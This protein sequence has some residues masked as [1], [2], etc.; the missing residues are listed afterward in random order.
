MKNEQVLKSQFYELSQKD[1]LQSKYEIEQNINKA[2]Y[3]IF[4]TFGENF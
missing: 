4:K 1:F 2:V 3:Y